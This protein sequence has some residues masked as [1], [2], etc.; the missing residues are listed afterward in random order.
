MFYSN[1]YFNKVIHSLISCLNISLP[2]PPQHQLPLTNNPESIPYLTFTAQ[3]LNMYFLRLMS[4]FGA[5]DFPV[6]DF[7]VCIF[8]SVYNIPNSPLKISPFT[9]LSFP[10]LNFFFFFSLFSGSKS[11]LGKSFLNNCILLC[12]YSNNHI[13]VLSSCICSF[14]GLLH[15]RLF[16]GV[17]EIA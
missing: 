1:H 10:L 6:A 9:C 17:G 8:N 7:V 12:S 4:K 15:L 11:V 14:S 13:F 16:L 2:I 3:Y 5:L